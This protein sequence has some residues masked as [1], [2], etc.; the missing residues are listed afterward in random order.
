M[1]E[2]TIMQLVK[3]GAVYFTLCLERGFVLVTIGTIW[4]LPHVG[5]RD[6]PKLM[7][8]ITVVAARWTILR[9][10]GSPLLAHICRTP[11]A[12]NRRYFIRLNQRWQIGRKSDCHF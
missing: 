2:T 10:V 3:A 7:K 8:L 11:G 1:A 5:A 12:S 4:S 6:G 9:L